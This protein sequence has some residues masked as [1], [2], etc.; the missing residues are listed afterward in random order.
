MNVIKSYKEIYNQNNSK[1]EW[2]TNMKALSEKLG[3]CANMKEYKE[4][5]DN[6]IGSIADFSDII[7]V[8]ITNRHNTP[9][10]YSIMQIIGNDNVTKRLKNALEYLK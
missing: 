1:D 9:D 10:I 6:Y 3:F 7:R 8:C 5:P 2:F 4:N